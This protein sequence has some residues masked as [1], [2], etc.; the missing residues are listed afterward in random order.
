MCWRLSRVC[1]RRDYVAGPCY[2]VGL[3]QP[4]MS[5]IL[6]GG[7][8]GRGSSRRQSTSTV[9][10]EPSTK[11]TVQWQYSATVDAKEEKSCRTGMV[12][13]AGCHYYYKLDQ[14][15]M[16]EF[17]CGFEIRRLASNSR[18]FKLGTGSGQDS[19]LTMSVAS[20]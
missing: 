7:H 14:H 1:S 20:A 6:W 9:C 12:L 18:D 8:T 16:L 11:S 10:T 15:R 13:S 5:L 19:Q 4:C 3:K 17:C 2:A